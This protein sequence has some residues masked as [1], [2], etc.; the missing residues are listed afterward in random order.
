MYCSSLWVAMCVFNVWLPL[1]LVINSF[2]SIILS[3]V[4]D[5]TLNNCNAF[6]VKFVIISIFFNK[7]CLFTTHYQGKVCHHY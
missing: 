1:K 2:E 6:E 7:F 4:D 3:V 5:V